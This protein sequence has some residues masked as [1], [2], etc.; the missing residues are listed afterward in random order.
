MKY[1]QMSLLSVK[2]ISLLSTRLMSG[3][4]KN[5]NVKIIYCG[6]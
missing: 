3:L 5:V 1:L 4:V 2:M 6:G